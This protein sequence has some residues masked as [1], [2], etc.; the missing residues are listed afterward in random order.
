MTGHRGAGH[1]T[2]QP[3]HQS[4][5]RSWA[6]KHW[7]V[8]EQPLR[9]HIDGTCCVRFSIHLEPQNLLAAAYALRS[10]RDGGPSTVAVIHNLSVPSLFTKSFKISRSLRSAPE[11]QRKRALPFLVEG[12]SD[13]PNKAQAH[14]R[15]GDPSPGGDSVPKKNR[16]TD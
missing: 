12:Y 11:T 15:H 5:F 16:Q 6:Q 9:G 7:Y 3:D 4:L 1:T 8:T 13:K 2:A 14:Y 10:D